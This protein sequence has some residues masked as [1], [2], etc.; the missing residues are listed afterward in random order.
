[1]M[2]LPAWLDRSQYPFTPK[3]FA[4]PAGIMRYVDTGTG[5]PIVMIHSNPYWSFEYRGLIKRLSSDFRCIAPD[6]LGF[7]LSD[8]PRD[9]DYLPKDHAE[10]LAK[11]LDA[12]NLTDITFVVNDWGGPISLSSAVHHP[13]RVKRVIVTNTWCWPIDGDWYY[14]LFS[15][16][17]ES[18]V[19]R[20]L[21]RKHN[22]FATEECADAFGHRENALVLDNQLSVAPPAPSDDSRVH[23]VL[24]G[25]TP[26][27]R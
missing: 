4:V 21:I 9:W 16:F 18:A 22:F 23:C 20:R 27:R 1:M 14:R 11:L 13:D 2:T 5:A 10:N 6:H 15:G 12:L 26:S 19:G 8:K 17:V 3:E 24:L 25:G 7:G